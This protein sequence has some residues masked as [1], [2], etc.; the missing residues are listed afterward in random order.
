MDLPFHGDHVPS[1]IVDRI[2]GCDHEH[3][4]FFPQIV[5]HFHPS[6]YNCDRKIV[7]ANVLPF[8]LPNQQPIRCFCPEPESVEVLLLAFQTESEK[9]EYGAMRRRPDRSC[10]F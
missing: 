3:V 4:L 10:T 6:I 7:P 1:S 8:A 2:D 5:A 9:N